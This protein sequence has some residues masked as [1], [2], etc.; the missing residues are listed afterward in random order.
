MNPVLL[1]I[2]M[3]SCKKLR[4]LLIDC[5]LASDCYKDKKSIKECLEG[6][7]ERVKREGD[8]A[9][10]VPEQCRQLQ[11]AH[12]I[13]VRGMVRWVPVTKSA[14][15]LCNHHHHHSGYSWMKS[16]SWTTIQDL[17][18]PR[19]HAGD[20]ES[21]V[22]NFSHKIPLFFSSATLPYS[23]PSVPCCWWMKSSPS[24][25]CRLLVA[26]LLLAVGAVLVALSVVT[27]TVI[28][29]LMDTKIAETL[30][31]DS[32]AHPEY[33]AFLTNDYDGAP[34]KYN[35]IFFYDLVNQQ[36]L[37]LGQPPIYQERGPYVFQELYRHHSV[38]ARCMAFFLTSHSATYSSF[39]R[40]T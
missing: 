19:S 5:I 39:P 16:V 17:P 4:S 22:V 31:V 25:K 18:F 30:T 28:P 40:P 15:C 36:E 8:G 23:P 20:Q 12:L 10:G 7:V 2:Q 9:D 38:R 33:P 1:H 11:K 6:D 27:R 34:A 13:C 32:S 37:L 14:V 35:R 29:L 24:K 3:P 26:S 21:T